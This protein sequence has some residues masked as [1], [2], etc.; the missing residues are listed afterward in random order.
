MKFAY[1]ERRTVTMAQIITRARQAL[2]E[3]EE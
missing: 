1:A 3:T 2:G